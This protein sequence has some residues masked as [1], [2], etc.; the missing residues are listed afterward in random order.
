MAI[1]QDLKYADW[2]D[3]APPDRIEYVNDG[4]DWILFT[5]LST[6]PL[7]AA[8][9]RS[10]KFS[11]FRLDLDTDLVLPEWEIKIP[12]NWVVEEPAWCVIF[13]AHASETPGSPVFAME[14]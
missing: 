3:Q 1:D 7:V 9:R 12:A 4:V 11:L 14:V 13:Q 2:V 10:E 6:D 8:G 5:S